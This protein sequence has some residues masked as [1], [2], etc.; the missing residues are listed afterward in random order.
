[1][2][3]IRI[4]HV[5]KNPDFAAAQQRLATLLARRGELE[6]ART[7]LYDELAHT[8][9][10]AADEVLAAALD[11]RRPPTRE[12]RYHETVERLQQ[13]EAALVALGPA[14]EDSLRQAVERQREKVRLQVLGQHEAHL[15]ELRATYRRAL[16]AAARAAA[17]EDALMAELVAKGFGAHEHRHTDVLGVDRARLLE[18]LDEREAVG[19]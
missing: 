11:G 10:P 14:A 1:M 4:E 18:L 8:R 13:V 7:A 5:S 6:A 17:A 3:T 16:E 2:A 15:R 9:A 19:A 12:Q